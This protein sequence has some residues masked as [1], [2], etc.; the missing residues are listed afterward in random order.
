MEFRSR[1]DPFAI[2]HT[3]PDRFRCLPAAN[4]RTEADESIACHGFAR[5]AVFPGLCGECADARGRNAETPIDVT[6]GGRRAI[7]GIRCEV[8]RVHMVLSSHHRSCQHGCGDQRAGQKFKSDHSIFSVGYEANSG[9]LLQGDREARERLKGTFIHTLS[10]PREV[11]RSSTP[12]HL[13]DG[14]TDGLLLRRKSRRS[15]HARQWEMR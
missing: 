6:P 11:G 15:S 9:W 7:L 10:P 13:L 2:V 8:P 4:C 5:G 12:R 3:M 14:S 1:P